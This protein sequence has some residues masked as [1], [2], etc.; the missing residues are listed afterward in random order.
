MIALAD[1]AATAL[2]D[3]LLSWLNTRVDPSKRE[4]IAAMT[5]EL[6]EMNTGWQRLWWVLSGLPLAWTFRPAKV[7]QPEL[8]VSGSALMTGS[9]PERGPLASSQDYL[10]VLT[11]LLLCVVVLGYSVFL[12]PVFQAFMIS[13]DQTLD[14]GGV[15]FATLGTRVG[16]LAGLVFLVG[17]LVVMRCPRATRNEWTRTLLGGVNA[18]LGTSAILLGVTLVRFVVEIPPV[19]Q[20][21]HVMREREKAALFQLATVN[22]PLASERASVGANPA[23]LHFEALARVAHE[24]LRANDVGRVAAQ[25]SEKLLV[26]LPKFENDPQYANAVEYANLLAGRLAIRKGQ[27][28]VAGLYLLAAAKRGELP[29]RAAGPNMRLAQDML[30]RDSRHRVLEYLA[31]CRR[32]WPSGASQ[33][34]KWTEQIKTTGKADFGASLFN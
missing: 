13:F 4:W 5:A 12:L 7:P 26:M 11:T 19:L 6:E 24:A 17:A 8:A 25:V 29:V 34:D 14:V 10:A 23:S 3:R 20:Q 16:L 2:A 27:G 28:G 33:L 22:K 32:S 9:S 18:L 21:Q 15:D 31:L 1:R 30:R